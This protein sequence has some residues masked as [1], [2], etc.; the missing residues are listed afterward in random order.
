MASKRWLSSIVIV[1]AAA[2]AGCSFIVQFD[3]ESQ[4]CD[5]A[6]QCS[7]GF[8]CVLEPGGDGGICKSGS[9]DGG[10]VPMNDGGTMMDGGSTCTARETVCGG[11]G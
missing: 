3:P 11:P 8:T 9:S 5:S 6:G 10:V 1:V 2:V 4:P 7:V